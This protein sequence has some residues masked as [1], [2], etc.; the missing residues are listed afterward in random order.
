[1]KQR[2]PLGGI[3]PLV[4]AP[5]QK[6]AHPHAIDA[7]DK[8]N[9]TTQQLHTRV[10]ASE[11]LEERCDDGADALLAAR[12]R[13]GPID[14][15]AVRPRRGR[16]ARPHDDHSRLLHAM[17]GGRAIVAFFPREKIHYFRYFSRCGAR[18]TLSSWYVCRTKYLEKR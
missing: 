5:Q 16:P 12:H 18:T 3:R 9:H 11:A 17:L 6:R 2:G 8:K 1:M 7:T 15:L 4:L 13:A 14:E 10:A